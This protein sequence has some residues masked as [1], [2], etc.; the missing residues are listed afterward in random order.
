MFR[1]ELRKPVTLL[2][3]G[4][5][6]MG[7]DYGDLQTRSTSVKRHYL[8]REESGSWCSMHPYVGC[9]SSPLNQQ[10]LSR[11]LQ[12]GLFGWIY[13]FFVG[14]IQCMIS[15]WRSYCFVLFLL[16]EIQFSLG[17]LHGTCKFWQILKYILFFLHTVVI[18]CY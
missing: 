15:R 9:L 6:V 5:K 14:R 12:R 7:L 4:L 13:K 10:I 8:Q 17:L 11:F 2:V 3:R 16:H 1:D 18:T